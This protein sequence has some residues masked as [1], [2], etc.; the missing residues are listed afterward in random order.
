MAFLLAAIVFRLV[1][2]ERSINRLPGIPDIRIYQLEDM[3]KG[4]TSPYHIAQLGI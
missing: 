3:E 2:S 1:I 4:P